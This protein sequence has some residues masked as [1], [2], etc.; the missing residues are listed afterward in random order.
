MGDVTEARQA[1]LHSEIANLLGGE[2]PSTE[3]N[4]PPPNRCLYA[5]NYDFGTL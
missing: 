3:Q 2:I 5:E 4:L 1:M